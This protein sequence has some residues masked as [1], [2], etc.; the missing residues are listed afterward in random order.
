[1]RTR[2]IYFPPFHQT[3]SVSGRAGALFPLF[4]RQPIFNDRF[5]LGG[6]LDVRMFKENGLGPRD[7]CQYSSPV[8][9]FR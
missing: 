6:P 2:F 1:M 3:V 8:V 4:G 7:G 9:I 5:Q